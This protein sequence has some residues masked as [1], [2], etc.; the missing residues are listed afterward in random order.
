MTDAPSSVLIVAPKNDLHAKVVSEHLQ[1]LGVRVDYLDTHQSSVSTLLVEP[2]VSVELGD[3]AVTG[4]WT[5][6]WRHATQPAAP[7]GLSPDEAEL[8]AGE[9]MAIVLGGLL[10]INPRWVDDPYVILKA[11][12]TL[13]QLAAASYLGVRTPAT[14]ATSNPARAVAF[15]AAGRTVAKTISYGIGLA[16]YADMISPEDADRVRYGATVLQRH[17][18]ASDDLRVVVV[19]STVHAW[20]RQH[21]AADPVD[22]RSADPSGTAFTLADE[23]TTRAV[24]AD[25]VRINHHLG[26]STSAQD[27]LL[28]ADG[29]PPVFLEAN[30]AGAW[31]FLPDADNLIAPLLA[32][33]LA[34]GARASCSADTTG[35]RL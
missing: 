2:G 11:E 8:A 34:A 12:H 29:S 28:P 5:I 31:L 25:A 21:A 16:P 1:K 15:A 14:C 10:S 6:W 30:P 3:T 35:T 23:Q 7:D 13:F 20:R 4:A 27:W 19:N 26:L 17:I 24:A 22:W 33:H 18:T 32:R 9:T